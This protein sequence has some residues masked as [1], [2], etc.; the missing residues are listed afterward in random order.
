MV[1]NTNT[2]KRVF[3]LDIIRALAI[4]TVV[5]GH[6]KG[7][8]PEQFHGVYSTINPIKIDG[9]SIFFVL[10]GFLIGRILIR[11][12]NKG[13]FGFK[14]LYD[15]WIRRWFRTLPNYYFTLTLLLLSSIVLNKFTIP[16]IDWSYYIFCQNLF[17]VGSNYYAEGWSLAVEEWFYLLLPFSVYALRK[18]TTK[19]KSVLIST[20]F[21]L[22]APLILRYVRINLGEPIALSELD[23]E[24]RKVTIFRLDSMMYGILGAIISINYS[25]MWKKY[26]YHA[27]LAG[28]ILYITLIITRKELFEYANEWVYVI[29]SLT[30]LLMLPYFSEFKSTSHKFIL[31]SITYISLLSYSMYLLN[32]TLVRWHLMIYI[33]SILSKLNYTTDIWYIKYLIYWLVTIGASHLIYLYFEMPMTKRRDKYSIG[34]Y[35]PVKSV[36]NS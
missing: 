5:Y 11:T 17:S 29:E 6:G 32:F 24:I 16:E 8:I 34:K 12:I 15:F 22:I 13:E 19:R 1:L 20:I 23:S 18:V 26:K 7:L 25:G 21:F 35:K 30:V 14:E 4:L 36:F 31:N 28:V 33:N 9:V 10:S 2:D 3:G 27:L